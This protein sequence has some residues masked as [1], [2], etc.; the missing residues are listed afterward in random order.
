M[1]DLSQS[2]CERSNVNWDRSKWAVNTSS[3]WMWIDLRS[4]SVGSI[5]SL[6]DPCMRT[7]PQM[8]FVNSN[9]PHY[10]IY[11]SERKSK[12][13]EWPH[14]NLLQNWAT[15]QCRARSNAAAMANN[16]IVWPCICNVVHHWFNNIDETTL[17][18]AM[19]PCW[20][21]EWPKHALYKNN[22]RVRY[23]LFTIGL[24]HIV[25]ISSCNIDSITN[26]VIT[27]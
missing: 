10:T 12:Y 1:I 25:V 26:D 21:R 9:L 15:E 11:S 2:E 6:N 7:Y 23:A 14:N 17:A 16:T 24:D 19:H 27:L 20:N 5:L 22:N 13:C 18:V 8:S 4:I 3:K